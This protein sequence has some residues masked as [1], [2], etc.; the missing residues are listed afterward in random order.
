MNK[1]KS[2]LSFHVS[3]TEGNTS[4]M[5]KLYNSTL[6]SIR[7]KI[8]NEYYFESYVEKYNEKINVWQNY[9]LC[10][11]RNYLYLYD[12]K[13]KLLDKPK[14]F[15]FLNNKITLTFHKKLFKLKAI[16]WFVVNFRINNDALSKSVIEGNNHNLFI[17]LKT[18][19]NYDTFVKVLDNMI[20]FKQ[21]TNS[22]SPNQFG[23]LKKEKSV[24]KNEK[25]SQDYKK[26]NTE[27][28]NNKNFFAFHLKNKSFNQISIQKN[29]NFSELGNKNEN[30]INN[31]DEKNNENDN[32]IIYKEKDYSPCS[33]NSKSMKSENKKSNSINNVFTF[34][35]VENGSNNINDVKINNSNSTNNSN[36]YNQRNNKKLRKNL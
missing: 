36:S 21:Y 32:E 14:E 19:K 28:K 8:F 20:K 7:D 4:S 29:L 24:L 23:I 26:I 5:K 35:K 17:S 1:T 3:Q 31:K 16:K 10:V 12:K 18:Q 34:S 11:K 15:L 22:V 27:R 33:K 9:F 6:P 30:L 25:K 13:P 2:S